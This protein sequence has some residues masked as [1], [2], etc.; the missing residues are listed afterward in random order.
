MMSAPPRRRSSAPAADSECTGN[1]VRGSHHVGGPRA[2]VVA[3][4]LS[5]APATLPSSDGS[6]VLF[7]C[8]IALGELVEGCPPETVSTE[9][10]SSILAARCSFPQDIWIVKSSLYCAFRAEWGTV[11]KSSVRIAHETRCWSPVGPSF[12]LGKRVNVD[13]G[14]DRLT[15]FAFLSPCPR[16]A[17]DAFVPFFFSVQVARY[18][19][20]ATKEL[21]A[22]EE[23]RT[24]VMIRYEISGT[25]AW[26]PF[27]G[28]GLH[29][30]LHR[31]R[32]L[33]E[34][35]ALK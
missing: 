2:S 5:A 20:L 19:E 7:W 26:A 1:K 8:A 9:G 4:Q 33:E 14:Q 6:T 23:L 27:L 3:T 32:L 16:I 31:S 12:S 22:C 29:R 15:S 13:E 18:V 10:T 25:V 34:T 17:T 28:N 30:A 11:S 24:P 21:H 35:D